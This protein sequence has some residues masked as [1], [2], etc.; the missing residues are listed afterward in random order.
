[1]PVL[2]AETLFQRYFW[3]VY[4]ADTRGDLADARSRDANPGGN[5]ELLAHLDDAARVFAAMAP[6][7]FGDAA[8]LLDRTDASVHRLSRL[9]TPERRDA[10][11]AGGQ[12]GTA[13]SE[14]FN[15]GVHAAAYVGACVVASHGGVWGVRRPLWESVVTLE[16]R[17][18]RGDL[19][20]LQWVLKS[21]ADPPHG[22]P[23]ITLADRYRTHVEIPCLDPAS[24]PRLADDRRIPRLA[25]VRYSSLHQHLRAHVPELRDLG[26]DFP[27]A[28]RFEEMR[29]TWLD[30]LLVGEGRMLLLFGPGEGGAHLFWLTASG[31][32]KSGHW[33]ADAFPAPVLSVVG[34]KLRLLTQVE[35]KTLVH[36]MLWWGP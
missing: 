12:A 22:V 11:A 16:S 28:E 8:P 10:W 25:K 5:P 18:G 23:A 32:E 2:T 34:E 26:P 24:L 4:P 33:P 15:V 30:F 29:L 7:L 19:A 31:F 1:M 27:S 20:V 6:G 17:A 14:L 3:P 21:L 35:G 9:L 13:E 36:E